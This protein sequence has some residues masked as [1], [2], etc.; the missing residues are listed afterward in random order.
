[1]ANLL[2]INN[3]MHCF[4]HHSIISR[5]QQISCF[6]KVVFW[7]CLKF[8]NKCYYSTIQFKIVILN[9]K[10]KNCK[11]AKD[12]PNSPHKV[13]Q[14]LSNKEYQM[15]LS[16]ARG[17]VWCLNQ[18]LYFPCICYFPSNF[19]TGIKRRTFVENFSVYIR[20]LAK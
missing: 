9:S 11:R 4:L 1:M 2:C 16:D 7:K 13:F 19:K 17:C 20:I 18:S 8:R 6:F 15:F 14:P 12:I 10:K 5:K 3:N